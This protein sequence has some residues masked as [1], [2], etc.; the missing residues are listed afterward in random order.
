VQ[1]AH[2]AS[3][4]EWDEE[5]GSCDGARAEVVA[6]KTCLIPMSALEAAPFGLVYGDPIRVRAQAEN[7]YGWGDLSVAAGALTLRTLPAQMPPPSRAAGTTTT[8]LR[9]SWP[10]LVVGP[11]TGGAAVTSYAVQWDAGSGGAT[12]EHLQGHGAP[13][14]ATSI[15]I[16]SGVVPGAGYQVRLAA[17]NVYGFGAP[18]APTWIWAAQ[19]P[20]EVAQPSLATVVSGLDV[21][22][23]WTA[24]DPNFEPLTAYQVLIRRSDGGYSEEAAYCDGARDPAV[25]ADAECTVP[26]TVLTTA[27]YFLARGDPVLFTVAA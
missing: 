20:S 6:S 21:V 12:W 18:S 9:L 11:A 25:L 15:S 4:S 8:L 5:P 24:P 10:A 14:L 26:L 13:S 17:Q 27:P 1:L 23:S 7:L 3:W 19:E 2:G 22:F 16:T